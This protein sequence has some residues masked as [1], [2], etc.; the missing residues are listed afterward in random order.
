MAAILSFIYFV[1][2]ALLTI[3]VWLDS[4]SMRW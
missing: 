1:I 4:S 2:N 3:F